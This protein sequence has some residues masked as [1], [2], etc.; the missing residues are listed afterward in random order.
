[1]SV[2]APSAAPLRCI[3]TWLRVSGWTRANIYL[4]LIDRNFVRRVERGELKGRLVRYADDFV[5]LVPRRPDRE[6]GWLRQVMSRLG[7]G[8]HP[9]KTRVLRAGKEDFTFLGHQVRWRY[10][11]LYLDISKKA[12]VRI[13]DELRRMRRPTGRSLPEMIE[14]LNPYIR[15]ARQNF[16]RVRRRTLWN[17]NRFV[18]MRIARWWAR[19]HAQRRPAWSLVQ[20]GNLQRHHGLESWYTPRALEPAGSRSLGES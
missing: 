15:G 18:H 2:Q 19:K 17:L 20:A 6:I 5:V 12:L 8:L 14:R 1:M 4:N 16:R 7:L 10:G 13:R 9:D 3:F 11:K